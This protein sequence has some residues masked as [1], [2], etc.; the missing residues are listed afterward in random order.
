MLGV[1]QIGNLCASGVGYN[2]SFHCEFTLKYEEV[3]SYPPNTKR[4]PEYSIEPC[5][6]EITTISFIYSGNTK[7]QGSRKMLLQGVAQAMEAHLWQK[8]KHK[9]LE[10]IKYAE[11]Q[12]R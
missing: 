3:L 11:I 4:E 9:I 8:Y 2:C 5:G 7:T 10:E 12:D 1:M 6:V